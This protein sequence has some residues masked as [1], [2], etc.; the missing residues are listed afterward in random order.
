MSTHTGPGRVDDKFSWILMIRRYYD[1]ERT[2]F[3]AVIWIVISSS[4]FVEVYHEPVVSRR[5]GAWLLIGYG[6]G[7]A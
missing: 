2:F 4:C 5:D 1:D 7:L 6:S 3:A